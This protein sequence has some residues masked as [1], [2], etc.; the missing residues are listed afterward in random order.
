MHAVRQEAI[1]T[2]VLK[3]LLESLTDEA[4][5]EIAETAWNYYKSTDEESTRSETIEAELAA[6]DAATRRLIQSIENGVDPKLVAGRLKELAEQRELLETALA[7]AQIKSALKITKDHIL[8]FLTKLREGDASDPL[9]QKRL[10]Q[11]FVNSV[12]VYEDGDRVINL[13]CA[14]QEKPLTLKDMKGRRGSCTESLAPLRKP[15]CRNG[16]CAKKGRVT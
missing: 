12:F 13:N 2:E 10:I 15:L 14:G 3:I 11:T 16:F 6:C 7:D 8:F 1:E 4:L 9:V 5:E